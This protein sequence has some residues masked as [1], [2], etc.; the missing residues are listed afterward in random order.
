MSA[1]SPKEFANLIGGRWLA[2]STGEWYEVRNPADLSEVLGRFPLSGVDDV[3]Q[4]VEASRQALPSWSETPAPR[5]G[6]VVANFAR[7]LLQH[8]DE[9]ARIL[10]LEEGKPLS[11]ARAE[12]ERAARE[13]QYSAGEATRLSGTTFPSDR[14]GVLCLTI[15]RPLGVVAAITPWNFP[16]VAPVRKIAPA[17]VA[18][19]T[20]VFKPASATPW[21]AVRIAELL[22][23]A[24]VPDGVVNL[25]IGRGGAIGDR[26]VDAPAV[27]GITFTGST[28]VGVRLYQRAAARMVKVQLELGGK[29]PAVVFDYPD[30]DDAAAQIVSAAFQASGQ[31]CTAISRVIVSEREA[32][33]LVERLAAR[34]RALRVGPGLDPATTMGPLIS[35]D[36]VR[37][38]EQYVEMGLAEGATLV[39]GGR[40]PTGEIYERGCYFEP[41]LLDHVRPD[42]TVAQEEIFGPVLCVTRVASFEEALQA[43]NG[44]RYGLAAAIF[45][46]DQRLAY[47]FAEHAEAGMVHLNHGTA[48]EPH[49]PFGG[50]KESGMGAY[51]IGETCKDFF[52]DL[53]VLYIKPA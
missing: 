22:Q 25:I 30:L 3:D 14:P 31:R 20:V 5:R 27:R 13:A 4:A 29:N 24:G 41:T 6:E 8:K 16:V 43:A 49:V 36:Q 17:L 48:S 26:L 23:E 15:R 40:R 44:V 33:A 34:I 21:T 28:E 50:I 11:E 53:K 2:P 38:V 37:R 1:A 51:S 7:L 39:C 42:S 32:P 52:T 45:T 12:V 47:R 19:N 46:R 10:T 35:L 18:G 9:L